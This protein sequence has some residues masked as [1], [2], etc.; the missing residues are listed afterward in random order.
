MSYISAHLRVRSNTSK[1]AVGGPISLPPH[2]PLV[3]ELLRVFSVQAAGWPG[4]LLR[5]MVWRKGCE[6][7]RCGACAD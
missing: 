7:V 6:C 1:R 2:T 4:G 3:A 5:A